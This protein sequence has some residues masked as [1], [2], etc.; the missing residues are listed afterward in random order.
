MATGG[1]IEFDV[2]SETG[3]REHSFS[4]ASNA[5]WVEEDEEELQMA[6]LFRLPTQKRS[7][8]AL[9]RKSSSSSVTKPRT[10]MDVRKLNRFHRQR[11]V[12]EALNTNEQDYYNLLFAIKQRLNRYQIFWNK[13]QCMKLIYRVFHFNCLICVVID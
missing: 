12:T 13:K 3:G 4:A 7:N 2:V 10:I 1:I 5:E 9:V 6:A 8:F 11:I